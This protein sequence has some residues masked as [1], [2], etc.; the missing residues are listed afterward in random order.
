MADLT[1]EEPIV[2]FNNPSLESKSLA[3]APLPA[4][5]ASRK[6]PRDVA[7]DEEELIEGSGLFIKRPHIP[8][9]P[10]T[11][12]WILKNKSPASL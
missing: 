5:E 3:T 7:Q 10:D 2:Q 11:K 6:C 1:L 4:P 8:G 12:K 9:C